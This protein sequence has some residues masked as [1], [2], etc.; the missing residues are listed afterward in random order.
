MNTIAQ[1]KL[2]QHITSCK[3]LSGL[4][5][6]VHDATDEFS[7]KFHDAMLNLECVSQIQMCLVSSVSKTK[8]KLGQLKEITNKFF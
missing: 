2:R 8:K 7:V 5:R 3:R 6:R 4:T 1:I